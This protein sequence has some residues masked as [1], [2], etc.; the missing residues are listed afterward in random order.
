MNSTMD[1]VLLNRRRILWLSISVAFYGT[2]T[3]L[4]H[5]ATKRTID[6][7]VRSEAGNYGLTFAAERPTT[8][9]EYGHAFIVWQREDKF[10][11]MSI[12][13]AIGFYPAGEPKTVNVIFGTR[14][15]LEDDI[16]T[17]KD[18]SLTVLLN[19]DLYEDALKRKAE[20][21]ANGRYSFLWHNCTIHVADIARG[22]GLISSSGK[23][24]TPMSY[25]QDLIDHNK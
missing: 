2:A 21:R 11:K 9:S 25:V 10:K 5:A 19:S 13:E 8:G 4:T 3:H 17:P 22:I 12:A 20:W 14:G 18:L 7:R 24:E 6:R 15:E 16:N 1:T 23:W